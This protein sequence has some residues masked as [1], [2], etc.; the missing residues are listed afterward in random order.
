MLKFFE[1]NYKWHQTIKPILTQFNLKK[2]FDCL[3]RLSIELHKFSIFST[4]TWSANNYLIIKT[5]CK[6]ATAQQYWIYF[7][8]KFQIRTGIWLG[9]ICWIKRTTSPPA[10]IDANCWTKTYW[11]RLALTCN[12][13][14]STFLASST[15]R[16]WELWTS[17]P[18][19][20]WVTRPNEFAT[21]TITGTST[22]STEIVPALMRFCT[23]IN[24]VGD[25]DVLWTFRSRFSQKSYDFLSSARTWLLDFGKMKDLS[26][27]TRSHCHWMTFRE[28]FGFYS[29]IQSHRLWQD[30]SPYYPWLL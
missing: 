15:R 13:S 24:P 18:T 20:C 29:S 16:I 5:E 2:Q 25:W 9:R 19:P 28:K 17:S 7:N 3:I 26:R 14:R 10:M 6:Y 23:F 30:F 1:S 12:E 22:F 21:M 8:S 11:E 4:I 27:K